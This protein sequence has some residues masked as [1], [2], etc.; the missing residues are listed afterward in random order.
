MNRHEVGQAFGHGSTGTAQPM[1][2]VGNAVT[3][4]STP[5]SKQHGAGTRLAWLNMCTSTSA[6][7]VRAPLSTQGLHSAEQNAS[8]VMDGVSVSHLLR[9]S[10][11]GAC[12][13]IGCQAEG[14]TS[15]DE[16]GGPKHSTHPQSTRAED[17]YSCSTLATSGC[18]RDAWRLTAIQYT[19]KSWTRVRDMD[20]YVVK[21]V[22]TQM[23]IMHAMWPTLKECKSAMPFLFGDGL[24]LAGLDAM[25]EAVAAS[26]KRRG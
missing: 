3:K 4:L 23:R 18:K 11:D 12:E 20:V 10:S 6:A 5:S 13:E 24:L 21:H 9:V 8:Q 16:P 26:T 2:L 7:C 25:S 17:I 15:E 22:P 19:T 14:V 1:N